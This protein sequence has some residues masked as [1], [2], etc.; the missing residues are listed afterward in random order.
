MNIKNRFEQF[1]RNNTL[2]SIVMVILGVVLFL[3]PGKTL[4]LAAK[5]LSIG[6]L[7][8]A[9]ASGIAWYQDKNRGV[10]DYSSLAI[11]ILCLLAGLVV[12]LAP[13]GIIS[14]LPKLIGVA[15][16]LNGILNLAQAL[17]MRKLGGAWLSSVV[18][19]A[20]TIAAGVFMIFFS[21]SAMKIAV[22]AIG[23]VC[24]YNGLSNLFIESKYKKAQ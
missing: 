1:S 6:L 11:A 20:L 16:L 4:E 18:M 2:L 22:M 17:V 5:I 23:G 10:A 12:L 3:W 8:G 13:R 21:F 7:V 14:L 15:V 9:A 19:A 24:V